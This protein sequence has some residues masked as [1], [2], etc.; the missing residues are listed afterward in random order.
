MINSSKYQLL[1]TTVAINKERVTIENDSGYYR[2]RQRQLHTT[3]ASTINNDGEAVINNRSVN[4]QFDNSN[5]YQKVATINN[6]RAATINSNSSTI[7]NN[8]GY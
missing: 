7:N 2:Q 3:A 8:S 6:N 4:Y 5:N 1:M